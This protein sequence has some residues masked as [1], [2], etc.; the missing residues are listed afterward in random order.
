MLHIFSLQTRRFTSHLLCYVSI[1]INRLF[2][3][4]FLFHPEL[5]V[6][7][8]IVAET[9]FQSIT[10]VRLCRIVCAS[11][12]L[13]SALFVCLPFLFLDWLNEKLLFEHWAQK[14]S[15]FGVRMCVC[16]LTCSAGTNHLAY[17]A[18]LLWWV[19]IPNVPCA[20]ASVSPLFVRVC[21]CL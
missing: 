20:C 2:R 19:I 9:F 6:L 21:V 11:W 3:H 14:V 8:I 10:P 1:S 5:S 16:A 12:S 15:L 13:L 18:S 4:L 17:G 7:H